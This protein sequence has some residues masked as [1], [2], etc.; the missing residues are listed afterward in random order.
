M[1]AEI[2][3]QPS[4]VTGINVFELTMDNPEDQDELNR[5][6]KKPGESKQSTTAKNGRNVEDKS[7]TEFAKKKG[8]ER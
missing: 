3:K 2:K 7:A 5:R 8:G 4:G 1:M 6:L